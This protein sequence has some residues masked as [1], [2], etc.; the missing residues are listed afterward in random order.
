MATR[1]EGRVL[2]LIDTKPGMRPLAMDSLGH[3]TFAV[4]AI[5]AD[6]AR[7]QA[8]NLV[9]ETGLIAV[10]AGGLAER[11]NCVAVVGRGAVIGPDVGDPANG[12]LAIT[13]RALCPVQARL[14]SKQ[15]FEQALHAEPAFCAAYVR[16]LQARLTARYQIAACQ[17]RHSLAGRCAHW[18]L[19]L[20]ALFGV[21]LP[22]THACLAT[23]L[24]VRRAGVGVVLQNLQ[25]SGAISQTRGRIQL[26]DHAA[27][28][29]A[30]C[31][32]PVRMNAAADL[33]PGPA[34]A[35]W[36]PGPGY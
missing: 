2:P 8:Y 34:P 9:V 6:S 27:V 32:C 23:I 4:G 12:G 14:V 7:R 15:A 30:A 5:I 25:R 16:H 11:A 26:L 31:V 24:G 1:P 19:E 28:S 10:L 35:P 36:L 33:L 13:Y 21:V 22:V 18:L 20:H 3:R 29:A 17:M